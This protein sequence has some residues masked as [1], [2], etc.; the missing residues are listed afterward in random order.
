MIERKLCRIFSLEKWFVQSNPTNSKPV[1]SNSQLIWTQ[2]HFPWR[3]FSAIYFRLTWTPANWNSFRF[4]WEFELAGLQCNL[5]LVT[6]FCIHNN[7][8]S[9]LTWVFKR[10]YCKCNLNA[11]NHPSRPLRI[12][13]SGKSRFCC[14]S[15]DFDNSKFS[16][17]PI[18]PCQNV[19]AAANFATFWDYFLLLTPHW[20]LL[21]AL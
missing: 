20:T 2:T 9:I 12:I 14:L 7:E 15:N 21:W 16:R 11:P 17:W 8:L 1:N 3:V 5:F 4:H 6:F 18:Q 10:S 19:P 13:L